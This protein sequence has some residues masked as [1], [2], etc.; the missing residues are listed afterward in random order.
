MVKELSKSV[1]ILRINLN[2]IY[3]ESKSKSKGHAYR[4]PGSPTVDKDM[5]F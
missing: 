5:C 1:Y 4:I 3:E 2:C